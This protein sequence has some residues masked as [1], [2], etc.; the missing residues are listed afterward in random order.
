MKLAMLQRSADMP[1]EPAVLVSP[2]TLVW[3]RDV[4]GEDAPTSLDTLIQSGDSAAWL[5]ELKRRLG[6]GRVPISAVGDRMWDAPIT[7]R[8]NVFCLG[9]NYRGH[10]QEAV[11]SGVAASVNEEYPIFFTKATTT[12]NRPG[13]EVVAPPNTQALDYEAELAVI[14]GQGGSGIRAD[15][16][17]EH[18]FGYTLIN[19]LTARDLQQRHQQWFLGKSLDGF[20]PIGP[21]IVTADEVS[22]PVELTIALTVNGEER[23]RMNTRD[24]IFD[25]PRTITELSRSLTLL[26][27]DVIATGTGDGVGRSFRPP[28]YLVPGDRIE[29]SCHPIGSLV[30]VIVPPF[31]EP[32]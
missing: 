26:P 6:Q 11:R 1:G 21:L 17:R 28:R 7:F 5:S 9:R 2:A 20:G 15:R 29:I 23:Q 18:I 8:R 24:M 32:P 19:D 22:W 3:F 30:T 25:I 14:I 16:A 27:G 12:R 31:P 4:M 13:G 10:A